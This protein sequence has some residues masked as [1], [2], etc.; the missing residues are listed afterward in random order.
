MSAPSSADLRGFTWRMAPL[1]AMAGWSSDRASQR[2]AQALREQ[3]LASAAVHE[4]T[5]HYERQLH[6]AAASAAQALDAVLH[7]QRLA[8]LAQ[9]RIEC[10][11]AQ[12]RQRR[13]DE[14][15]AQ[16]RADCSDRLRQLE[17]LRRARLDAM[18]SHVLACSSAQAAEA[19]RR[20]LG[21]MPHEVLAAGNR[22]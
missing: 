4:S 15:V 5:R 20:W 13:G 17:G 10:R 16:C 7:A 22:A 14:E 8:Y 19:D 1:H 2:L 18:R 3:A 6:A 12:D 9:L 21:A 11:Q